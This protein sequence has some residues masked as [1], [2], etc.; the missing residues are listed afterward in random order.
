VVLS[1]NTRLDNCFIIIVV[2]IIIIITEGLVHLKDSEAIMA[3]IT[4]PAVLE[5]NKNY[6]E[7]M[8]ISSE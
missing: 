4:V 8:R 1:V 7:L 5:L 3:L 2:I 6:W